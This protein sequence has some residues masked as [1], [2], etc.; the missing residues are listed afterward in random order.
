MIYISLNFL[1]SSFNEYTERLMWILMSVLLHVSHTEKL[2]DQWTA[3]RGADLREF[4]LYK[5]HFTPR[6]SSVSYNLR[7]SRYVGPRPDW[8]M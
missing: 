1:F 3:S 6:L 4:L 8:G 2:H 7:P 5:F